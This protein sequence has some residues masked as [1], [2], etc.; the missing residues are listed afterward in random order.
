MSNFN[1]PV[2]VDLSA[3]RTHKKLALSG[4]YVRIIR[5]S[6][7]GATVKISID[8]TTI[9]GDEFDMVKGDSLTYGPGFDA[10]YISNTAQT[11]EWIEFI[12][13]PS[14]EVLDFE[15]GQNFSIDTI[16]NTVDVEMASGGDL[17]TVLNAIEGNTDGIETELTSIDA[18]LVDVNTELNTITSSVRDLRYLL[19][20]ENN[21]Y[22]AQP[23]TKLAG[24][25]YAEINNSSSTLVAG[26]SNT[27]GIIVRL[28]YCQ[29]IGN[30]DSFITAGGDPICSV[31]GATA[32]VL[33]QWVRDIF[34][35]AGEALA[36][37]SSGTSGWVKIW[38][39]VI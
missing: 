6:T 7:P 31:E 11:D 23:T 8:S 39:D 18:E 2:R 10:L 27:A 36:I 17:E 28:G 32:T 4:S 35:P 5:S 1:K 3:A 37:S 19:N 14:K 20:E 9:E 12:V 34:I 22:G 16:N 24:A 33:N 21:W 15:S 38:Y 25:T 26:G 30:N 13:T 29:S